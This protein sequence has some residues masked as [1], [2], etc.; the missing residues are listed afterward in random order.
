MTQTLF[1][2]NSSLGLLKG[3]FV[4]VCSW[5]LLF[6]KLRWRN[7]IWLGCIF[8]YQCHFFL[9]VDGWRVSQKELRII[10]AATRKYSGLQVTVETRRGSQEPGSL[11]VAFAA[12]TP[13]LMWPELFVSAEMRSVCSA[14]FSLFAFHHS[15]FRSGKLCLRGQ[16]CFFRILRGPIMEQQNHLTGLPASNLHSGQLE[17]N[18]TVN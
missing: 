1:S 14:V 4:F 12:F 9:K 18:S 7:N 16:T 5:R 11:C 2:S 13:R 15:M 6:M 3:H 8:A 10:Y 17:K